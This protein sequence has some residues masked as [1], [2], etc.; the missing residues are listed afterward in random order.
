MYKESNVHIHPD[1]PLKA[2]SGFQGLQKVHANTTLPKKGTKKV[3][4]TTE[5]K[6]HNHAHSSVRI[7]VEHAIRRLKVFRI[8]KEVYRNRRKRYGLRLNLIAGLVNM[9]L[10]LRNKTLGS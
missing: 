1:T 7:F 8:L 4:L 3:P 2:D 5:D 10:E 9:E 6:K